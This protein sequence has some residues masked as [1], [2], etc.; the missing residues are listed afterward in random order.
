MRDETRG[1][2]QDI[3]GKTQVIRDKILETRGLHRRDKRQETGGLYRRDKRLSVLIN[4]ASLSCVGLCCKD[5]RHTHTNTKPLVH[6]C[7][8]SRQISN[9]MQ[10]NRRT[11]MR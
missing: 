8:D 1:K 4:E 7:K 10:V 5:S 11:D 3:R 9:S 2:T 6:P